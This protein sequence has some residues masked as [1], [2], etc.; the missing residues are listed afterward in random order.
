MTTRFPL[1]CEH[2][3]DFLLRFF[4][5]FLSSHYIPL[6][7]LSLARQF[8]KELPIDVR[9][10]ELMPFDDNNWSAPKMI[11]Y[12]EMKDLIRQKVF[13]TSTE[14]ICSFLLLFLGIYFD[15]CP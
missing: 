1:S 4:P 9:F 7:T 15:S 12:L 10:I 6:S 14:Y 2:L 3:Y 8:A 5:F 13:R 11:S